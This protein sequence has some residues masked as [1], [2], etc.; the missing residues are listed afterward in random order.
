MNL[1]EIGRQSDEF[2]L[3]I[4]GILDLPL[5]YNL[6]R[7]HVSRTLC[8]LA[9]EYWNA[10]RLLVMNKY[11]PSAATAHRSQFES[12]VRSIWAL[13]VASNDAIDKLSDHLS[14]DSEKAAKGIPLAND[15][16]IALSKGAPKNI[17]DVLSRFKESSWNAL[18][19]FVHSGIHAVYRH[20]TG[21]PEKLLIDIMRN[22]NGLG[23]VSG[24]QMA[25][26]SGNQNL[27]KEILEMAGKRSQCMP[28]SI[29]K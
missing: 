19:S 15:M 27:Q 10:T 25:I 2:A 12:I 5:A 11:L 29:L 17:Y 13:N 6:E 3:E 23:V 28:D 21:Y 7:F 20:K 18:N 26:L 24:M 4:T 16:I 9:F 14:V 22:S 1:S 8:S